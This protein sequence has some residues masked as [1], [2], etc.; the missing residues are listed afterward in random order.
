MDRTSPLLLEGGAYLCGGQCVGG[1]VESAGHRPHGVAPAPS[2]FQGPDGPFRHPRGRFICDTG[3]CSASAFLRTIPN[4]SG[5]SHRCP[6]VSMA[7]WSPVH[8]SS[9]FLPPEGGTQ[10]VAGTGGTHTSGSSLAEKAVICRPHVI[11]SGSGLADSPKGRL[12]HSGGSTPPG[13]SVAPDDRLEVERC[14]LSGANIPS[15]VIR[16]I[17]V[18]RRPSTDRIYSAT[19]RAFCN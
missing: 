12:S 15:D 18:S 4:S 2:D 17:Q 9:D 10:V 7:T 5:G 13:S 19:W 1:L 16:T 6:L 3:E 14:A 8:F 11:V